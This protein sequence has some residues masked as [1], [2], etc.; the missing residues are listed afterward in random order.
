MKK[1]ALR[2][3]GSC[4]APNADDTPEKKW[5]PTIFGPL[6]VICVPYHA[7]CET[8]EQTMLKIGTWMTHYYPRSIFTGWTYGFVEKDFS[9]EESDDYVY[10]TVLRHGA[11]RKKDFE[12]TL[13]DDAG[14]K[15]LY[16]TDRRVL[17]RA[18][19]RPLC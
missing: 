15:I 6:E 13:L 17:G 3:R 14:L 19:Q 1:D 4:G 16:Y 5:F 12:D 8:M 11:H 9:D 18:Y 2:R 7:R 10:S